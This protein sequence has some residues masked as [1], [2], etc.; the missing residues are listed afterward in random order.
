MRWFTFFTSL[1]AQI[2]LLGA[3]LTNFPDKKLT[4]QYTL[5][6]KFGLYTLLWG[7]LWLSLISYVLVFLK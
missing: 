5:F 4:V 3:V 1:L 2:R 7:I 6:N